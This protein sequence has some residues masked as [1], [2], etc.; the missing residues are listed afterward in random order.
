MSEIW[1]M[2]W[3]GIDELTNDKELQIPIS[4]ALTY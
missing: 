3:K 4:K 1:S 2:E